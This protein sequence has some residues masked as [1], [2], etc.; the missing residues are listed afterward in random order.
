[1]KILSRSGLLFVLLSAAMTAAERPNIVLFIADDHG[2]PGSP[3]EGPGVIEPGSTSAALISF[4]D[5]LP[6]RC[7]RSPAD[8]PAWAAVQAL[9]RA[10]L[11]AWLTR[12]GDQRQYFAEPRLL[13]EPYEPAQGAP[14]ARR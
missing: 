3:A 14:P 10:K 5:F 8:E 13:S 9:L 6:A 12:Q 4:V 11:D 1:M 2:Y 7:W